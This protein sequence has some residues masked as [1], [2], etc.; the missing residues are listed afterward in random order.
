MDPEQGE[1]CSRIVQ[2]LSLQCFDQRL[3]KEA[4]SVV[5]ATA[6][7]ADRDGDGWSWRPRAG[8]LPG[9]RGRQTAQTDRRRRERP[10]TMRTS[11]YHECLAGRKLRN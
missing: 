3:A 1:S 11:Q 5:A 8:R 9:S 6:E 7:F 4:P 2:R 10:R